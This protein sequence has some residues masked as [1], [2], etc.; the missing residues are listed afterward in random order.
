MTFNSPE[1]MIEHVAGSS[2]QA[3]E[4]G[5]KAA[6]KHC[7]DEADLAEEDAERFYGM[8]REYM[9]SKRPSLVVNMRPEEMLAF[10]ATGTHKAGLAGLEEEPKFNA[11][12]QKMMQVE[13][14]IGCLGLRPSYANVTPKDE[15]LRAYG[16]CSIVLS[17]IEG[18]TVLISG[19]S[20]RLRNPARQ[21]Y[22]PNPFDV[23][24]KFDDMADCMAAA[25][26]CGLAKPDLV[27]GPDVAMRAI[28]DGEAGF[29]EAMIFD[30]IAPR[31]IARIVADDDANAM[32]IRRL[33]DRLNKMAPVVVIEGGAS[34]EDEP[35]DSINAVTSPG[36]QRLF[37]AGDRVSMKPTASNPV[38]VGTILDISDGSMTVEWDD[39]SRVIYDMVEAWARLM[40]APTH[41]RSHDG[42]VVYSLPGMDA[43]TV[44]VLSS[45]GIDPVSVYSLAS[46]AMPASP[47]D[48]GWHDRLAMALESIGLKA[49]KAH[50]YVADESDPTLAFR[51]GAWV[52]ARLQDG[53]RLVVDASQ[54]RL[55][56]RAGDADDY[57]L[58]SPESEIVM[59]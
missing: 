46:H 45:I 44:H 53:A 3:V 18:R 35:E 30:K 23:I 1:E 2:K 29:C 40:P 17:G 6:I 32:K 15:G 14:A 57:V 7:L 42:E 56:V 52:E 4:F 12:A 28:E 59:E 38:V 19:D 16:R 10:L 5:R 36:S 20:Y 26:I 27:G 50:G 11:D 37:M 39:E 48:E 55:V 51:R 25:A 33:L 43:E 54:G 58:S 9:A 22:V 31:S 47:K 8:V 34:M 13:R 41:E 24:Y 49:S 21:D